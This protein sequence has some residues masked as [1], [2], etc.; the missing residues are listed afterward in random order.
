MALTRIRQAIQYA[1]AL[2]IRVLAIDAGEKE[3]LCNR[4]GVEAFIDFK[5]CKE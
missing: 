4:L 2:G 3:D 5:T 1:R